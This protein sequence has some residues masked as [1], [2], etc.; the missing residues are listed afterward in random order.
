MKS[1]RRVTWLNEVQKLYIISELT[2]KGSSGRK[3]IDHKWKQLWMV[4]L[5]SNYSWIKLVWYN[6]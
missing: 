6:M 2:A 1:D 4:K 3:K 5:P